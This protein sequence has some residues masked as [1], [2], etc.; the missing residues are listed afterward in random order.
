LIQTYDKMRFTALFKKQYDAIEEDTVV[1]MLKLLNKK[2]YTDLSL[3]RPYPTLGVH[4]WK[5]YYIVAKK[6]DTERR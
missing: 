1:G 3:E 6:F 5:V 2:G 4:D